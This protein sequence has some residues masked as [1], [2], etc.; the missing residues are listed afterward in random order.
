VVLAAG[1]VALFCH[2]LR[3]RGPAIAAVA[4]AIFGFIVGLSFTISGGA[5]ADIAYH[6]TMLPILIAVAV[7]L[8]PQRP[9]GEVKPRI[10]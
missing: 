1:A 5:A 3:G 4:F 2:P 6:V 7:M 10:G 8:R 9:G